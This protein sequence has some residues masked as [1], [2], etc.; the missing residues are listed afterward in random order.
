MNIKLNIKKRNGIALPISLFVLVGVLL[1][2]AALIRSSE[3]S[4]NVAGNLGHRALVSN[5]NDTAVSVANKWLLD[6]QA[7]LNNDNVGAGYRSAYPT[8]I[9]DYTTD[10]AWAGA[11][12]L[13]ADSFGNVSRYIIYRMCT[14]PNTPFN[15][16]NAGIQNNCAVKI[17][18]SASNYG[19]S[20][21]FGSYNF[22][23]KPQL[24][25]KVVTKTTGAKNAS[26]VT[27]TIISLAFS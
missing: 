10:A 22:A 18:N 4:I 13:P 8:G 20:S 3:L 24:Y 23:G 9:P 16:S 11:K 19:N 6:N 21:G 15:G 1:A 26:T 2:S 17:N 25:F 7:T 5:S 27:E 14:Q 12:V